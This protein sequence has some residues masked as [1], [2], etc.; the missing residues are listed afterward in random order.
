[1]QCHRAIR[2]PILTVLLILLGLGTAIPASVA[3][4]AWDVW[5]LVETRKLTRDAPAQPGGEV[6]LSAARNEWE[7]FQLFARCDGE[8][9]NVRVEP[10]ALVGPD[11]HK[12]DLRWMRLYRQH[13]MHLTRPTHRNHDFQPGW[14]PDPLIPWRHPSTLEPLTG[15]EYRAMPFDLPPNETHGFWVDLYVPPGTPSGEYRGRYRV[16][17]DGQDPVEVPV[18]LNVWD[19]ELPA[20][21]TWHTAFG[22]PA[23]R[24]RGYYARL[25][26][27][28]LAKE[29]EGWAV[30]ERQCAELISEHR[31]NAVP[32]A[33]SL[34]PV[35]RPD[36]TFEIPQEQIER[37]RQFIDRYRIN[38]FEA[39]H[40]DTVI[41]DP[42]D[43][44]QLRT[45]AAWLAAWDRAI[46]AIN[47]PR[48]VF[49]IYL[50]REPHSAEDYVY[51][52]SWGRAIRRIGTRL[53]V[54]VTEQTHPDKESYGD[55]HGCVD[56]WCP[57]FS[58]F[59]PK[60]AVRRQKLGEEIWTYTALCQRMRTPWWHIDY[61]LL[62]YR[63]P[64][65][66]S[67]RF[68]MSGLL[69]WGGMSNWRYVKDPWK[70]PLTLDR[71]KRSH[72]AVYN[73]EGVLVYP[74]RIVGYE[75]IAPSIRLKALRDGIEDYEYLTLAATADRERW[76]LREVMQLTPHW[77]EW[78][79]DPSAYE[80]ARRELAA[81]ILGQW[82]FEDELREQKR[83][84]RATLV[85]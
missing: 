30:I 16:T 33:G 22:S 47:R 75:G 84:E 56:I 29:P 34:A 41:D 48:V 7:S 12:L 26:K 43:E 19:F 15:G 35:A 4:A 55:L 83:H 28:G 77:F 10:S 54:L 13:Q 80:A 14:Y 65:W 46:A 59:R 68:G 85:E 49:Y 9:K 40:P 51:V 17:G 1:M 62:N 2:V 20:T 69:Y 61:P 18:V 42:Y 73:G 37:F 31:I 32:P 11:G 72:G 38:A 27:Q 24:M 39:P 82:T 81:I 52:Q 44:E 66:T 23:R 53:R 36:G 79:G 70:E 8:V 57:L 58:Q 76:I 64:A 60:E 45:L 6:R 63:V 3:S 50:C 78:N 5:S 67:W 25:A 74:A 71:T 21:P